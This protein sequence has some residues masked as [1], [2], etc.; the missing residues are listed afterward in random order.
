MRLVALIGI[1]QK[2]PIAGNQSIAV[3]SRGRRQ[4]AV[5]RFEATRAIN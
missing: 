3:F 2:R 4:N 5:G 1:I